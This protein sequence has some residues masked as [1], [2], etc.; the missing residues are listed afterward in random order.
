[1][2]M[3]TKII[4]KYIKRLTHESVMLIHSQNKLSSL[5]AELCLDEYF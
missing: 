2:T 4:N 1:M 5:V 3:L